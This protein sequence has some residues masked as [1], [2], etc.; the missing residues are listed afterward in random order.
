MPD[1]KKFTN[2]LA[3]LFNAF[4]RRFVLLDLFGKIIP[5]A[6]FL[7]TVSWI[8]VN[9]GDAYNFYNYFTNLWVWIIFIGISWLTGFAIQ[10]FGEVTS[11]NK[12]IKNFRYYPESINFNSKLEWVK[13]IKNYYP[14]LKEKNGETKLDTD[15]WHKIYIF[16]HDISNQSQKDNV[17]R[18]VVIKE[19]CGNGY[20]A[21]IFSLFLLIFNFV[22]NIYNFLSGDSLLS[23]FIKNNLLPSIIIIIFTF[24]FIISLKKMHKIQ[25]DNQW[26]YMNNSMEYQIKKEKN[27]Y[28]QYILE[29]SIKK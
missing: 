17:A 5:G 14:E 22:G 20:I 25:V 11:R 6:I 27:T 13:E 19:A 29:K 2:E 23:Y 10:G 4:Y 26:S 28:F 1:E 18:F 7:I 3:E 21:L 8:I 24:I 12:H 15:L 9:I 16:F